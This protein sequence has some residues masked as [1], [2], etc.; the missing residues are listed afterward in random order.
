MISRDRAPSHARIMHLDSFAAVYGARTIVYNQCSKMAMDGRTL[1]DSG[2][3]KWIGS[4]AAELDVWPQILG[5]F[6]E[7]TWRQP[8][9]EIGFNS[10]RIET[11]GCFGWL[12]T[13]SGATRCINLVIIVRG[14]VYANHFVSPAPL[15]QPLD[16]QL[17]HSPS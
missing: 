16:R 5:R 1:A 9:H 17:S 14:E 6:S 15:T 13:A 2:V 4:G 11:G 7:V 10:I 12:E 3:E 8:F